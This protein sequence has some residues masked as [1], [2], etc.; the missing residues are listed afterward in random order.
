MN[1]SLIKKKS[2][3]FFF[4]AKAN[5]NEDIYTCYNYIEWSANGNVMR[6]V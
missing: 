1:M 5:L 2:L 3:F 6:L 4:F